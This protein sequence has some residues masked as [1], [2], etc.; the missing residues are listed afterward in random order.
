MGID[1]AIQTTQKQRTRKK[2]DEINVGGDNEQSQDKRMF[3]CKTCK[4]VF[5]PTLS[6]AR[7]FYKDNEIDIYHD[8]PSIG[9]EKVDSCANCN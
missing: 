7:R 1:W 6:Y 9:K 5:Q 4:H 2:L 8:F 3:Y